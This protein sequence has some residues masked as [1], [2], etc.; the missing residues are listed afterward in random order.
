[1]KPGMFVTTQF[2]EKTGSTILIPASSLYQMEESAFVFI[3]LGNDSY[4]KRKVIVDGTD[5]NRVIIKSGLSQ[6]EEI[7]TGGGSLLLDIK[8]GL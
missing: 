1:M 7:V 5:S 6:N 8:S 2:S 3:F 4:L